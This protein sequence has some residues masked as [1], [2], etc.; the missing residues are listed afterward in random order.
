MNVNNTLI[1]RQG[2]KFRLEPKPKHLDHLNQSLGANRF[3]WNKLLAMNLHR[4][5]NG[6]P[7]LWYHEMAWWITLWKQSEDYAYLREAPAQSLQQT[8]KALDRAFKDAFNKNQPHKRL[9]KPKKLG[10]NEA[11]IKYPQDCVLDEN[12]HV[13]KLPKL[14]WVKYHRSQSIADVI[15]NVTVSRY[16]GHYWLSVQTEREIEKPVHPATGE[17]GI[18]LGVKRLYTLSNGDYHEPLNIEPLAKQLIHAQRKLS[19]RVKFSANWHKQKKRINRLH[20]RIANAR[21]DTLHKATTT[22]SQNHAMI[23]V[24]DLKVNQM[25]RSAKGTLDDPGRQ[26]RQKAGLNKAILCQGWGIFRSQLA[27]KQQWLGGAVLQVPARYS[28]QTCPCCSHVSRDNRKS[29][30][31]FLCVECGYENHADQVG[32]LNVLARGQ[33]LLAG[34][35]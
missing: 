26:V 2:Y 22:I 24:E 25:T 32:A 18:D 6:M 34:T 14:G 10:K 28:S 7:I 19:R 17:I 8:A 1:H 13:I 33:A 21:L 15:K 35:Q 4:L 30:A 27:Y 5:Q 20:T 16:G 9:P 29:Q 31:E 23:Y 12:N 11:G 3:A